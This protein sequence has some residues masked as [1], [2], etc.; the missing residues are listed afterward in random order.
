MAMVATGAD[1]GGDG[2]GV[3]ATRTQIG[4]YAS[5]PAY[6]PV[7]DMHGWGDLQP[8]LRRLSKAGEW[9]AMG[10]A[11]DD[12]MVRTLAVVAE[13]DGVLP[14]LIERFGGLAD[15]VG[16]SALSSAGPAR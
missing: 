3:A 14:A 15:R 10:D 4:F 16:V 5:T 1:R 11:V 2:R 8:E 13:P 12:E 7:L 6:R 9:G